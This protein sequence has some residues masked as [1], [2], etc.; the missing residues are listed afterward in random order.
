MIK[1]TRSGVSYRSGAFLPA[2]STPEGTAGTIA[3]GILKA[4][5][6]SGSMEN[7]QLRFDAMASHDITYVGIIQTAASS[8][9]PI[10]RASIP[11]CASDT[12]RPAK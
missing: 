10:R 4:H 8:S 9:R 5:N 6:L 3:Y 7:L 12:P 1:V 2:A 11:I